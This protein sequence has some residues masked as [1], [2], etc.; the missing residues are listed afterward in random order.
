MA[1]KITDMDYRDIEKV[2]SVTL[3]SNIT[4]FELGG[5][6]RKLAMVISKL[7]DRAHQEGIEAGSKIPGH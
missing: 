4:D 1:K 7:I 3:G 6:L 2:I 5:N